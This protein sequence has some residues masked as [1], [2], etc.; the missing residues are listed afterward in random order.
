MPR[1]GPSSSLVDNSRPLH[2][3]SQHVTGFNTAAHTRQLPQ[4]VSQHQPYRTSLAQPSVAEQ[5]PPW[6]MPQPLMRDSNA[7]VQYPQHLGFGLHHHTVTSYQ[8]WSGPMMQLHPTRFTHIYSLL[9][10]ANAFVNFCLNKDAIVHAMMGT[11]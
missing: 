11:K 8:E 6:S 1:A 9:T 10:P 3:H 4:T 7:R 5:Q 2:S